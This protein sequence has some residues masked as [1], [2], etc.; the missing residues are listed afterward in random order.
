MTSSRT[1]AASA[2]TRINGTESQ[3][4][5]EIRA[6]GVEALEVVHVSLEHRDV[7]DGRALGR[8]VEAGQ[9]LVLAGGEGGE[10]VAVARQRPQRVR[11]VLGQPRVVLAERRL[12][13]VD[14]H[15]VDAE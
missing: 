7:G 6:H 1:K 15:G 2:A 8:G 10:V 9:L 14:D 5:L 13:A 4:A 11:R 12:H 3:Y